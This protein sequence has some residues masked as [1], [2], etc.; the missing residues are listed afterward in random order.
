MRCGWEPGWVQTVTCPNCGKRTVVEDDPA[1][2]MT[3]PPKRRRRDWCGC[4]WRGEWVL[5]TRE[6]APTLMEEWDNLN[7]GTDDGGHERAKGGG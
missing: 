5:M 3:D 4:G 6:R 1:I 7:G 2:Y